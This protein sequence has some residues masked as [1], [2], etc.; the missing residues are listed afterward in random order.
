MKQETVHVCYLPLAHI[1]EQL[2]TNVVLLVGG[3]EAFLTGGPE[4][5]MADIRQAQP[6]M[7]V[8]VPRVLTRLYTE[9]HKKIPSL[10]FVKKMLNYTIKRKHDE[11]SMGKFDQCN[12][13]DLLLFKR[14][15]NAFGGRVCLILASGAPLIPEISLF[16]RAALNCP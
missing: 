3:R 5:L 12:T 6:T 14:F 11:Q 15:R 10:R 4:T 2:I 13:I 8:A 7:L 9:Y 1:F 16:F